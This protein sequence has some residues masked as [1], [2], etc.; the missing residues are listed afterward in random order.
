MPKGFPV[1]RLSFPRT[2]ATLVAAAFA[3][4]VLAAGCTSS[5]TTSGT[6]APGNSSSGG[7]ATSTSGGAQPSPATPTTQTPTT[8][9]VQWQSKPEADAA[10]VAVDTRVSAT[11]KQGTLTA[12]DV[13]Y[14]SKKGNTVKV[15]GWLETGVWTASDLLEPGVTYTMKLSA[16]DD[17]GAPQTTTRT[18]STAK[19]T[20]NDQIWVGLT[21]QDGAVVGIA[22]PVIVN[23][24]LPVKDRAA[25]QKYMTVETTPKQEGSWYWLSSREAHWRPKAYWTPGTK[26]K[27]TAALNGIPDGGGRFGEMTRTSE[28]TIG[29]A[30]VGKVNLQ[31]H[32][33]QTYIGGKLVKTIPISGGRPGWETRSGI[34]VIMAK[35]TDFTMKAESIGLKEGDKDW[36]EDVKVNH[37]LQITHSGEFLHSAPWS[38]RQQGYANVSH[39]CTG[40]SNG[41]SAWLAETYKVGDPVEYT[42]TQKPMTMGNG[43]ADWNLSWDTW[44]KGSAA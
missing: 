35:Y 10:D 21:P 39:G 29:R 43:Y 3:T 38:V 24:D 4:V 6:P 27:V 44:Q 37:A 9:P 42:G 41:N 34:K 26:V 7:A 23:F 11:V 15:D 18:F 40:M 16:T 28:F 2:P 25:F 13:S 1:P 5:A 14:V 12:A 33:M 36:Y 8:P 19:L 30:V 32:Q 20:N 17:D 31:T 22:M